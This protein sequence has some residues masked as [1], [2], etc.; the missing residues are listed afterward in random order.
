MKNQES[1]QGKRASTHSYPGSRQTD[2]QTDRQTIR[3]KF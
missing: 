3:R 1:V 2:R